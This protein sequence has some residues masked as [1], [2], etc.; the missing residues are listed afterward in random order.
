MV[1]NLEEKSTNYYDI[2]LAEYNMPLCVDNL[3]INLEFAQDSYHS[4]LIFTEEKQVDEGNYEDGDG[5]KYKGPADAADQIPSQ[6]NAH[7]SK[8]YYE[9]NFQF[10]YSGDDQ[11]PIKV[12]I[13]VSAGQTE[14]AKVQ[15]GGS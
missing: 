1:H 4:D 2:K 11:S 9:V 10:N 12:G 13:D 15:L 3:D 5:E 14:K 8:Q 6:D 7:Q